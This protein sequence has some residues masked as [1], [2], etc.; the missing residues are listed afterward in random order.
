MLPNKKVK[1]LEKIIENE[2]RVCKKEKKIKSNIKTESKI[3][4]YSL[5]GILFSWSVEL[6]NVVLDGEIFSS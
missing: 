2:W 5:Q 3:D 1:I 4:K 6:N